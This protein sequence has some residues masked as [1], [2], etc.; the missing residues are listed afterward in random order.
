MVT[1]KKSVI[2]FAMCFG[3]LA[4]VS[5]QFSTSADVVSNYVWRGSKAGDFSIQPTIKYTAGDF[6]IG[7]WGSYGI[8]T[9]S[10]S[11]FICI[12]CHWR[13]RID[14]DGLSLQHDQT[15]WRHG[16]CS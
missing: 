11:R 13:F 5:A 16:P 8:A 7:A 12:V 3:S 15:F 9:S 2:A 10:P 14:R 6:T 1:L 4:M